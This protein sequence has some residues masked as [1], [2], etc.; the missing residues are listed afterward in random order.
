MG[1]RK[2]MDLVFTQTELYW[3]DHM[4]PGEEMIKKDDEQVTNITLGRYSHY[5]N[6]LTASV[7]GQPG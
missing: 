4:L 5:Y 6:H 2:L 7:P 1:V 3:L